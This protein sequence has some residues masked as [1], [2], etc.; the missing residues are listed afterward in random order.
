LI[1][2]FG[3]CA[4]CAWAADWVYPLD[5]AAG[6]DGEFYIADRKLPGILKLK[7]GEL[8]VLVAGEKKFRTPLNAI[9]C[10]H[11]TADGT[12]L[13]GDSA[14]RE[15][16]KVAADGQLTPLTKGF[17]GI[18]T[19]ISSQ[20]ET[21]YVTDLELARVWKFPIAGG[22]PQEVAV[23]A[24]PRGVD[25]DAEGNVWILSPQ[26]PQLR[27][28]AAD[29]TET[30]VHQGLTFEFPQEVL[31]GK[32]GSAY[33]SDG[34]AKCIWKVGAD[35]QAAKW[36]THEKFSNPVGMGWAGD[37]LLLIDSRAPGLFRIT[38]AGEVTQVYPAG[39]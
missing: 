9:R 32:D 30:V 19:Q 13:A 16:Y 28:V 12:L 6:K 18:P 26:Q 2:V 20:G 8:S 29:K 5:V 14:T 31:V 17:V 27:K 33:V 39:K 15:V 11:V 24:G 23:V 22:E 35:G 21:V 7:D 3:L 34:Y 4:T 25:V 1:L 37:D 36:A 38:P 10:V